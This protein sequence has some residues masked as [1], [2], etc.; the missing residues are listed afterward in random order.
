MIGDEGFT[1]SELIASMGLLGIILGVSWLGYGVASNGSQASDR[2]VWLAREIGAPLEQAEK[3]LMQQYQIDDS[4]PGAT[5]YRIK[6]TTDSDNDG[7]AE[8]WVIEATADHR[9]LYSM[10]EYNLQANVYDTPPR[11][12]AWSENNYNIAENVPLFRYYRADGTEITS[13]SYGDIYSDASS[14]KVTIVA[15]YDEHQFTDSRT[16]LFRN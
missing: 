14:I 11:S 10:S 8:D 12:F 15:E 9:L 2:Q 1:L 5:A 7:H 13:G 16:I 6:M 3:V 4:Y